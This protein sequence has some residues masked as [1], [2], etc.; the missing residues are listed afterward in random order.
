M[1]RLKYLIG[2]QC[3]NN[4]LFSFVKAAFLCSVLPWINV[5]VM[6]RYQNDY[7]V[8]TNLQMQPLNLFLV[9]IY[10]RLFTMHWFCQYQFVAF[11]LATP[12]QMHHNTSMAAVTRTSIH[13]GIQDKF[14]H[15]NML[16]SGMLM[17]ICK[18]KLPFE[19]SE[20]L[21]TI[22]SAPV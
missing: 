11:H 14:S 18:D 20:K 2:Y 15:L 12:L 17:K 7:I 22:V 3:Y 9:V 8:V 16:V 4:Q 10:Q 5:I 19:R 6:N 13:P 21:I 1:I